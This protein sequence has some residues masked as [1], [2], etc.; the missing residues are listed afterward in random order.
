MADTKNQKYAIF[1]TGGFQY[2]AGEGDKFVVPLLKAEP[3]VEVRFDDVLALRTENE[4][5]IG[6]PRVGNAFVAAKV[7]EHTRN[8]KIT[9]MKF[10]RRENYRRKKGHK[11]HMT[12]IEITGVGQAT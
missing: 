8:P 2:L 10:I 6:R 1:R 9:I 4:V 12:M 11:Q 7:V 3:G 5:L